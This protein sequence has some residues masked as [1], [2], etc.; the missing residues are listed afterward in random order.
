MVVATSPGAGGDGPTTA[1]VTDPP[2]RVTPRA[3]FA[4]TFTLDTVTQVP[5]LRRPSTLS[6]T[7]FDPVRDTLQPSP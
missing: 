3:R 6:V 2:V 4:A 5:G 7:P 1:R